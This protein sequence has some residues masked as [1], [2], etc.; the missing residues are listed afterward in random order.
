MF[1]GPLEFS[2]DTCEVGNTY[3]HML[4]YPYGEES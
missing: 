3:S 4:K 1:F 2:S